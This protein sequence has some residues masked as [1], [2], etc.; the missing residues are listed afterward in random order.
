MFYF[1]EFMATLIF[2]YVAFAI[3]AT[4]C[5]LFVQRI[6]FTVL[7]ELIAPVALVTALIAGTVVG[8]LIKYWLDSRWIFPLD[9]RL[10]K[11]DRVQFV[12]YSLTGL[13]TTGLF[14]ISE[15]VFWILTNDHFWREVGA[16]IGLA[17]GYAVKFQL[18][19]KYVFTG[20]EG[21]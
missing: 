3:L 7:H 16:I 5:N 11:S 2:R 13:F 15:S 20:R 6:V 1:G 21:F 19:R 10:G 12:R 17:V 14:W 8:L 4:A 18:D 9:H